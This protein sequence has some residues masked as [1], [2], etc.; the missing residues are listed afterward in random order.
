MLLNYLTNIDIREI[1]LTRLCKPSKSNSKPE[2]VFTE[3]ESSMRNSIQLFS[4]VF[5]DLEDPTR[6]LKDV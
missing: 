4:P 2:I 1:D 6:N 5:N 3:L